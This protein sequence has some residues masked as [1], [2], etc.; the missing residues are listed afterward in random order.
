[1]QPAV[2]Q[3][4]ER[5][6]G[7]IARVF[8]DS[9]RSTHQGHLPAS[10][11][12]FSY[13]ESEQNW[14]RSLQGIALDEQN[15]ECIYI[16]TGRDG[17]IAGVAMGGPVR[18]EHPLYAGELYILYLLPAHQRQGLG[19]ALMRAVAQHLAGCG[20]QGLLVRVLA[21]NEPARNFYTAM[22]GKSILE[23]EVEQ[24]GVVLN[25]VGYAWADTEPLQHGL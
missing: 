24:E 19:R 9:M 5:E 6:A 23:E 13:E 18:G 17:R 1:M 10:L 8:I 11:L 15:S 7:E 22:G 16:A 21:S 25:L 20:M 14:K 4:K 12:D 3:A 2:R